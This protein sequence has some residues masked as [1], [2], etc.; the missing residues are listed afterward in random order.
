[1]SVRN[2]RRAG[3]NTMYQV[4]GSYTY[5]GRTSQVYSIIVTGGRATIFFENG[6]VQVV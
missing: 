5:R 6:N 4:G 2:F 3:S 1:M